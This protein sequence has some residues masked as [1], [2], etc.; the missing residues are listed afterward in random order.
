MGCPNS[1]AVSN[2]VIATSVAEAAE[3]NQLVSINSQDER[4]NVD[5][6]YTRI[7]T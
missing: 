3:A 1:K 4:Q 6:S 5:I 7:T 2:P